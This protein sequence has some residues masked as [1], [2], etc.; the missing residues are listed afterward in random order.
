MNSKDRRFHFANEAIN[1][2][3]ESLN[4]VGV[5]IPAIV[6]CVHGEKDEIESSYFICEDSKIGAIYEKVLIEANE[7]Q[8]GVNTRK[9]KEEKERKR[10]RCSPAPDM[11][12]PSGN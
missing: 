1:I 2:I 12:W 7:G 11:K 9:I 4:E 10:P 8:G 5:H 3:R 6:F